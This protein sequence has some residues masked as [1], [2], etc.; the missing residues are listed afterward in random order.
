MLNFF[1]SQNPSNSTYSGDDDSTLM[2]ALDLDE[3]KQ[4]GGVTKNESILKLVEARNRTREE[5]KQMLRLWPIEEMSARLE[6]KRKTIQELAQ[7]IA[8]L[9]E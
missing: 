6:N 9:R 8:N 1:Q 4:F 3:R 5:Y 7:R 2:K